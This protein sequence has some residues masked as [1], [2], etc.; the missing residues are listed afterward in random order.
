M[1]PETTN[2]TEKT[3][4][5]ACT[6]GAEFQCATARSYV[7]HCNCGGKNH[8]RYRELLKLRNDHPMSAHEARLLIARR[9]SENNSAN[10]K[11][12]P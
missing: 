1:T 12:Y 5:T 10:G 2:D 7:C 3:D 9:R 4:K 8:G 11:R 6:R